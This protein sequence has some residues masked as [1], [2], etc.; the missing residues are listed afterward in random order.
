MLTG[1]GSHSGSFL[2]SKFDELNSGCSPNLGFSPTSLVVNT[3]KLP[4][5]EDGSQLVTPEETISV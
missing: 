3:F 1:K 2:K 5:F 4:E